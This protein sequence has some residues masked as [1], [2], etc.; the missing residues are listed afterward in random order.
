MHTHH[1]HRDANGGKHARAGSD[2]I[3]TAAGE[4]VTMANAAERQRDGAP[5]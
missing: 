3:C 1:P 5:G 2:N 4:C